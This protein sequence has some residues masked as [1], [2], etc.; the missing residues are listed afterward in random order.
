MTG[1]ISHVGLCPALKGEAS[2]LPGSDLGS[3]IGMF[4]WQD[5]C[6]IVKNKGT[7][8]ERWWN[9]GGIFHQM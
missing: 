7:L 8:E 3:V 1:T 9:F 2:W 5:A 6:V 4:F